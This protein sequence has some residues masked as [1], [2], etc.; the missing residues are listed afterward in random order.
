MIV[1]DFWA[2]SDDKSKLV[3]FSMLE[4]FKSDSEF[5][6]FDF[7]P[8]NEDDYMIVLPQKISNCLSVKFPSTTNQVVSNKIKI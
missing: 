7:I 8:Q 3:D 2:F 1:F 5:D 4:L 6:S